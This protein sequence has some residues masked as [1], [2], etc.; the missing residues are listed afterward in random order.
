MSAGWYFSL[1]AAA[2][3]AVANQ[4]NPNSAY[5][6]ALVSNMNYEAGSNPVNVSYVCGLGVKRQRETVNQYGKNDRRQFSPTGVPIG[7][8][9]SA[10]DYLATYGA[11]G[12]ELSKLSFPSDSGSSGPYSFYDR[13]ADTWN[14]STEFITVNQARALMSVASLSTQT[15]AKSTAWKSGS[16]S[17]VVPAGTAQL[18]TPT[19]LT[20]STNMDLTN[21]R[22]VWEGRDQEPDFG[23]TYSYTPKNTG[24]QWAEVEIT[25]PDG[26]RV[27]AT[28]N[29]SANST[30]ASWTDEALPP[31][32]S[33]TGNEPWTW[34][35]SPTPY[36]GSKAHQS[37][38]SAGLT[39]HAFNDTTTPLV[40]V[41]GDKLFA[42]VYLDP[43]NVPTEVMLHWNNGN[44]DHRAYWGANSI[45]YGTDGTASRY[46]VG[47]LPAAGGWVRLVVPASAVGLEGATIKGM[48]FSVY[49]GR[50]TWDVA[51][52][53]AQ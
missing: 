13:W 3:M 17:I 6:D 51:G 11:S 7:N 32:A 31:S 35:S 18:N 21:A 25:W 1:D 14:T 16:A 36:S 38:I 24:A 2:D 45:N 27:F 44:W 50:A 5:T 23:S 19:V 39:E 4:I 9:H 40:L 15:T 34:V 10:Y 41:T 43:A 42:W 22:I 26:R 30:V 53:S 20:L 28:A 47:N 52:K 48:C 37:A 33:T 12:N 49:G 46:R 8:I 29:F